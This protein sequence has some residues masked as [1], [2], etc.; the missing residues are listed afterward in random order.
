MGPA[1]VG[2]LELPWLRIAEE[3]DFAEAFDVR[4]LNGEP[5]QQFEGRAGSELRV[6]SGFEEKQAV[7]EARPVRCRDPAA[8]AGQ[9]HQPQPSL[10]R[11][12]FRK[13]RV[14]ALDSWIGANRRAGLLLPA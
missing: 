7:S 3:V 6:I 5:G 2:P 13:Q 9:K 1:G 11:G 14:E 4:R 10:L 8:P 12:A